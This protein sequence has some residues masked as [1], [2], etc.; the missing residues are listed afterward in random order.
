MAELII[1]TIRRDGDDLVLNDIFSVPRGKVSI[2]K[3]DEGFCTLFFDQKYYSDV[4]K[5][6]TGQL[7]VFWQNVTSPGGIGDND[8]LFEKLVQ[9]K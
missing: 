4:L 3:R 7:D 8:E 6:H 1:T 5:Y 9:L 2:A